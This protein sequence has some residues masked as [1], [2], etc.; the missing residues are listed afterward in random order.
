MVLESS[1]RVRRSRTVPFE[2]T[3][4]SESLWYVFVQPFCQAQ[5]FL[6][7]SCRTVDGRRGL[8]RNLVEGEALYGLRLPEGLEA[9]DRM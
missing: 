5:E 1:S 3:V 2:A 7:R 4:T 8:W 6:E 9:R